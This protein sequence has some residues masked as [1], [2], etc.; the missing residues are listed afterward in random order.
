MPRTLHHPDVSVR[1]TWFWCSWENITLRQLS[2]V[3]ICWAVVCGRLCSQEK[4]HPV[5]DQE[6]QPCSHVPSSPPVEWTGIV[7]L[8]ICWESCL[9]Q[10][11]SLC[12]L[13]LTVQAHHVH[14]KWDLAWEKAG[15]CKGVVGSQIPCRCLFY[16]ELSFQMWFPKGWGMV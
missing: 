6:S 16:I 5:L 4:H 9:L 12:R 11:I 3:V 14:T 1:S 13:K 10:A 8:D 7:T 2:S 15:V